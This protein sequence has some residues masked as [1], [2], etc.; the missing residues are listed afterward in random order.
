MSSGLL[1]A[2]VGQKTNAAT[3]ERGLAHLHGEASIRRAFAWVPGGHRAVAV[4]VPAA[5][6]LAG[7]AASAATGRLDAFLANA[8]PVVVAFNVLVWLATLL[9]LD[10]RGLA[11][12][13][14]MREAFDVSD[15]RYY[16]FFADMLERLYAPLPWTSTD[17]DCFIH[18]PTA[19]FLVLGF[20]AFLGVPWALSPTNLSDL[21]GVAWTELPTAMRA[22]YVVVYA[23]VLG[24][25]VL[26]GWIASVG[27]VYMGR[28]IAD[29][30]VRLD[31]T[32]HRERLGFG[33]YGGMLL[34]GA[35]AALLAVTV[36]ALYVSQ[37]ANPYLVV[38]YA[39]VTLVPVVG[40]FAASYG[41]YRAVRRAKTERLDDLRETYDDVLHDWFLADRVHRYAPADDLD[42]FLAAKREVE[43]L[44]EWPV[45]ASGIAQLLAAVVASNLSLVLQLVVS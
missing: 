26:S 7:V 35:L 15:E 17:R 23:F 38:G 10:R 16:G 1:T 31:V 42:T 37:D 28:R 2:L 40:L 29:F 3:S 19:L 20:V 11:V 27:S 5:L 8:F 4:G 13:L 9:W 25:G 34:R 39:F 32:R 30:S 36:S 44:P 41:V 24:V 22:Y 45:N 6:Y 33:D 21:V 43:R 12:V 18:P 14:G